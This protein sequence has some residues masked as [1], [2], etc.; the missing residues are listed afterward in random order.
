MN[1][2]FRKIFCKI[3]LLSIFYPFNTFSQEKKLIEIIE[4]G[5]FSRDEENFPKANILSKGNNFRVKLYHDGATIISDKT[6]FYSKENK[7]I[8]NGSVWLKQGDSLELK[9][10]YLNYDGNKGKAK[11]WGEVVLIQP[12][13]TLKTDTLYLD[14]VLNIAYYDSKGIIDDKENILIDYKKKKLK[15]LLGIKNKI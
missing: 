6:F 2:I 10:D 1:I 3:I 7:F 14:R 11:A 12:D 15:F 4:A 8:A 5:K 9:S 13:M